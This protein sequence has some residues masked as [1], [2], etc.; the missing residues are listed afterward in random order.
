MPLQVTMSVSEGEPS[1]VHD[2]RLEVHFLKN[3]Y[4]ILKWRPVLIFIKCS[5]TRHLKLQRLA[6]AIGDKRVS[7]AC[8]LSPM[9]SLTLQYTL[10]GAASLLASSFALLKYAGSLL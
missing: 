4:C 8:V 7:R 1:L 5:Q 9:S 3:V 2:V 6:P 10:M